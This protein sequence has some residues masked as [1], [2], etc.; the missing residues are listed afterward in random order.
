MYKRADT[1]FNNYGT[2]YGLRITCNDTCIYC[3]NIKDSCGNIYSKKNRPTT[4]CEVLDTNK[5]TCDDTKYI[6]INDVN[7]L[8]DP[9][10]ISKNLDIKAAH[11]IIAFAKKLYQFTEYIKNRKQDIKLG[12][13]IDTRLTIR[14]G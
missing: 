12:N 8:E 14:Y 3:T 2:L 13:T 11:E 7:I 6:D 9:S 1:P 10:Y 5:C 4:L